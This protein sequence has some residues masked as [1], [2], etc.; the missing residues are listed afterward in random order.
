[1]EV[2]AGMAE[3]PTAN[4]DDLTHRMITALGLDPTNIIGFTLEVR[5]GTLPNLTVIHQAW[6]DTTEAFARTLSNYALLPVLPG[7]RLVPVP[8]PHLG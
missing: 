5:L 8:H 2:S 4:T 6:S 3:E 7:E 1:M